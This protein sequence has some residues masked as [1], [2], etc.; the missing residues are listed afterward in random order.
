M[1]SIHITC[2]NDMK[3]LEDPHKPWKE[4]TDKSDPTA[5]ILDIQQAMLSSMS[6]PVFASMIGRQLH[7]TGLHARRPI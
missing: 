6:L 1:L 7:S 5:T 3:F 4:R 2:T